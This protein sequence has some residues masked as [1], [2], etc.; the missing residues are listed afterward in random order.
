MF[1]NEIMHYFSF[2]SPRGK[3]IIEQLSKPRFLTD[4]EN[5]GLFSAATQ[6]GRK[7]GDFQT[8]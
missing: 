3:E 2:L 7:G 4:F 1:G 6:Q 5:R 8:P